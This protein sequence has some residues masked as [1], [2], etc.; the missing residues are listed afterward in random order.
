MIISPGELRGLVACLLTLQANPF[1]VQ[2]DLEGRAFHLGSPW[3]CFPHFAIWIP[4]VENT[5]KASLLVLRTLPGISHSKQ[6][7]NHRDLDLS[8]PS[9]TA[10]ACLSFYS[11]KL[12]L[13]D[14]LALVLSQLPEK[15]GLCY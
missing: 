4:R 12:N 8:I 10:E 1:L 13:L 9:R 15:T 14:M 5:R 3:A 11:V 7:L 2:R 6:R